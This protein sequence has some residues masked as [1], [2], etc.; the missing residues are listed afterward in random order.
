[1]RT[2]LKA[3]GA[4]TLLL[5]ALGSTGA[6]VAGPDEGND[7]QAVQAERNYGVAHGLAA[8]STQSVTK[9]QASANPL[10]S[11]RSRRA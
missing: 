6:A 5:A 9:D 1:M 8:S 4:V 2:S 11:P 10:A 7:E 3:V